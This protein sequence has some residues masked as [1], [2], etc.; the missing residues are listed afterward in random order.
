MKDFTLRKEENKTVPKMLSFS[1]VTLYQWNAG[2][3]VA[4]CP[5]SKLISMALFQSLIPF[6]FYGKSWHFHNTRGWGSEM[7]IRGV[8][9]HGIA[10]VHGNSANRQ[11]AILTWSV[12]T[13]AVSPLPGR[14]VWNEV[15]DLNMGNAIAKKITQIHTTVAAQIFPPF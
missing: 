3:L 1:S 10:E 9:G 14:W 12:C 8:M 15:S 4:N 6:T 13:V 5:L 11:G 7:N 2:C